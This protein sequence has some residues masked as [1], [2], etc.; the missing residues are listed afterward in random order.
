MW[1]LIGREVKEG[2]WLCAHTIK[3]G[4]TSIGRSPDCDIVINNASVSRRHAL[5]ESKGGI[6]EILDEGSKKGI[7]IR[8]R[9]VQRQE[10]KGG[11]TLEPGCIRKFRCSANNTKV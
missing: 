1:L 7:T 2:D 5:I 11:E 8:G 4:V 3:E 6:V 10:L 9:A